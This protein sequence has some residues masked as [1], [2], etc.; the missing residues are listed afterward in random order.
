M[1]TRR[2]FT[3]IEL[4]VVIS[5]IAILIGILLPTISLAK[6][7]AVQVACSSNLRQVGLVMEMYMED[8]DDRFPTARYM[9]PPIA[10]SDPFPP[11]NELLKPYMD[12]GGPNKPNKVYECPGDS[13]VF[14]LCGM[15]Y[16][17]R[18]RLR[19]REIEDL[20]Q[21]RRFNMAASD[22][23]V[24]RDFDNEDELQLANGETIS[25]GFF[26]RDRNMLFADWHVSYIK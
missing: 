20:W 19:G 13:Y 11:L 7:R 3:L 14:P 4:L 16:D 9:P 24:C 26:H 1:N 15:S 8:Y 5:I 17:Y 23:W 10:S 22:I 2:G 18:I 25:V 21:V 6:A 12:P